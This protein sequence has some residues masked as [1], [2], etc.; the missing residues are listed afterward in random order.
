MTIVL[1]IGDYIEYQ[2]NNLSNPIYAIVEEDLNPST[3][4]V[5]KFYNNSTANLYKE[6]SYSCPFSVKVLTEEEIV[7]LKLEGKI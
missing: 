2:V 7:L 1:K 3:V 5:R 6:R 4:I